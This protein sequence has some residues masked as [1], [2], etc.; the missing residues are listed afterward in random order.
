MGSK[1]KMPK[2]T[3]SDYAGQ[4][5]KL[6]DVYR[7]T[8][9]GVQDFER[10]ARE[11]YMG[12]NLGDITN[13]LYGNGQNG[14]IS[15]FGRATGQ[16]QDQLT[17]ARG[18]EFA[19]M[20]GQAGAVRGLLGAMSPESEQLMRNQASLA[21][22]SY[23][24]AQGLSGEATRNAQQAAREAYASRGQLS[25]NAS[26]A[27]EVLNREGA[28]QNRRANASQLGEQAFRTSQNYYSPVQG[29]LAGSPASMSLGQN[30][31]TTGTNQIGQ[32]TPKLFDYSTG[33]GMEQARVKAQDAYNQA[34]YKQDLQKYQS[35]IGNIA[36][37]AG[38]I[39]GFAIGGPAG[40]M[41]GAQLGG[42]LGGALGG[43][44][45]GGDYGSFTDKNFASAKD[46]KG[47]FG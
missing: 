15:Q 34:K 7:S 25:G 16:A 26:V 11:G 42:G 12:L 44:S 38:T 47:I 45:S 35:G 24:E 19:S 14:Y 20:T 40:A 18:A 31:M 36:T 21:N 37:L 3:K 28:V 5:N 10:S 29:L 4:T 39:G 23:Q 33:F 9:G 41:M 17:A 32:G 2:P 8:T 46:F 22:R 6:L 13:F 27:A 30:F 1:P 43:S